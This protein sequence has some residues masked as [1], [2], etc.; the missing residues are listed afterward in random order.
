MLKPNILY[1][2][3]NVQVYLN[4]QKLQKNRTGLFMKQLNW[5][6]NIEHI[7]EKNYKFLPAIQLVSQV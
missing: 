6:D 7:F 3:F 5:P 1:Q 4:H 2:E